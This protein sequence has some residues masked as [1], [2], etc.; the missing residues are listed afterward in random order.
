MP[1]T[2]TCQLRRGVAFAW[3]SGSG[4]NFGPCLNQENDGGGTV[5][6]DGSQVDNVEQAESDALAASAK[7]THW[8]R[9]RLA[10]TG[11]ASGGA[12]L[13]FAGAAGAP[14]GSGF[15]VAGSLAAGAGGAA[16]AMGSGPPRASSF[17]CT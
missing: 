12:S 11:T 2:A 16:A 15:P 3:Y 7:S 10:R 5:I 14:G 17:A 1:P 4:P 13:H 8:Q 6:H 9:A